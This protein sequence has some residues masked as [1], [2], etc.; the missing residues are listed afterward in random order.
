[1]KPNLAFLVIHSN[2]I[3]ILPETFLEYD[4]ALSDVSYVKL[5]VVNE[6]ASYYELTKATK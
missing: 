3:Y 4:F 6:D 5:I 2:R 1:M